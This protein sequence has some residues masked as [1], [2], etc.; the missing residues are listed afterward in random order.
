MDNLTSSAS[1]V[2]RGKRKHP[3]IA[4]ASVIGAT[5]ALNNIDKH[6]SDGGSDLHNLLTSD[7][8][9]AKVKSSTDQ[10]DQV[11]QRLQNGDAQVEL[12]TLTSSASI[13]LLE[14]KTSSGLSPAVRKPTGALEQVVKKLKRTSMACN[15]PAEKLRKVKVSRDAKSSSKTTE[16]GVK[17]DGEES[18][19]PSHNSQ[20]QNTIEVETPVTIPS[21]PALSE[22][23]TII[24]HAS[25]LQIVVAKIPLTAVDNGEEAVDQN[26][27]EEPHAEATADIL[28]AAETD[29]HSLIVNG[30][31]LFLTKF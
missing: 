10:L 2:T 22:D 6:P 23:E 5:D 9:T 20:H 3:E 1:V 27:G 17:E 28:E 4:T 25:E 29:E 12:D 26:E 19:Q 7:L 13:P 16:G 11:V 30:K 14:K 8:P 15:S 31:N 24:I 21:V 18:N